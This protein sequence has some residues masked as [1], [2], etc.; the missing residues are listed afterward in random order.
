MS[1]ISG[2]SYVALAT[3]GA[4]MVSGVISLVNLTV[5][6]EH[7]ISEL[8]QLWIDGLRQ[9]LSALLSLHISVVNSL[10]CELSKGP[11]HYAKFY[12]N[13]I[14]SLEKSTELYHRIKLRLNAKEHECLIA[15]LDDF[16]IS[17]VDF[18]RVQDSEQMRYLMRQLNDL[19]QQILKSEWERV[20]EGEPG[21]KRL[22]Q[23]GFLLIAFSLIYTSYLLSA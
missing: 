22:K 3:V 16:D 6:K 15:L 12:E 5:S 14:T 21:F 18:Q 19:S 23:L 9:D 7:K 8:R 11:V 17:I 1:G 4:A 13:H 10:T 20:K 2:D